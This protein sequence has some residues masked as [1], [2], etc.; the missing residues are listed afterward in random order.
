MTRNF[1]TT[2]GE[3]KSS[4]YEPRSIKDEMRENLITAIR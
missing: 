4:G 3:L 1:P 2:L